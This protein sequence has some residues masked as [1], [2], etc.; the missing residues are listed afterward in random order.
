MKKLQSFTGLNKNELIIVS[1]IAGGLL[2]GA[3]LKFFSYEPP[4]H[5]YKRA[6]LFQMIDSL[7][8]VQQSTYT[9]TD[10]AGNSIQEL[11]A[12]DTL[13]KEKPLYPESAKKKLPVENINLNTASRVELMKLP[14]VGE[15]TAMKI[16]EYRTENPF[17]KVEDIKNV[18]GIGDKKFQKMKEYI[19]VK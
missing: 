12:A 16:I 14:G 6:A 13:I 7:A 19:T 5:N 15:I 8:H 17:K 4:A 10:M 1:I 9:G 11:A 18:K 3:A 2:F